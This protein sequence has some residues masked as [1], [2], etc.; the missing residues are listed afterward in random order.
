M[1]CSNQMVPYEIIAEGTAFMNAAAQT[2]TIG[3]FTW[4]CASQ[5]DRSIKT[6]KI[7]AAEMTG[8][9]HA[10]GIKRTTT[11]ESGRVPIGRDRLDARYSYGTVPLRVSH[12]KAWRANR[13]FAPISV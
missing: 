10:I 3:V 6:Q 8:V 1:G 7:F 12:P 11:P 4:H 9:R 5:I 2:Q 13:Y